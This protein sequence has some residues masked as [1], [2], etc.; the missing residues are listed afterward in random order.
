M[1]RRLAFHLDSEPKKRVLENLRDAAL[2]VNLH[3]DR[4]DV[5]VRFE[6]EI[7]LHGVD[8]YE[9]SVYVSPV[10]VERMEKAPSK[11]ISEEFIAQT[12]RRKPQEL[13]E[14]VGQRNFEC[15][16]SINDFVT[17]VKLR[18]WI[19]LEAKVLR[20]PVEELKGGVVRLEP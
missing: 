5:C 4:H 12:V 20:F 16:E 9:V 3:L 19:L 6:E 11:D 15:P 1:T 2:G 14:V 13:V 10:H 18:I 8:Q 17:G 7:R